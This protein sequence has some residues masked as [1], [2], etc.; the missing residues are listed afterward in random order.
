MMLKQ[1]RWQLSALYVLAATVLVLLI[2]AGAYGML[3]YYFKSSTDLALRYKVAQEY[4]KL[5]RPIPED[6]Q[7]ADQAWQ[8]KSTPAQITLSPSSH[9]ED[10]VEI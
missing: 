6:L 5:G 2:G 10:E 3:S 7:S 1:L 4:I 8:N 9:E